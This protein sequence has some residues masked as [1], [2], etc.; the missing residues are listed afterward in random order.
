MN[1]LSK[2]VKQSEGDVRICLNTLQFNKEEFNTTSLKDIKKDY[3]D[4]MNRIFDKKEKFNDE[5][6]FS[7]DKIIQGC[8]DNYPNIRYDDPDLKKVNILFLNL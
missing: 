5:K 4:I 3:F 1:T 2:L 6:L 8:F 7:I